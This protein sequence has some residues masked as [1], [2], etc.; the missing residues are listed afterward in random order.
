MFEAFSKVIFQPIMLILTYP[1][2]IYEFTFSIVDVLFFGFW[3]LMLGLIIKC[4][5]GWG[6]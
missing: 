4:I 6:N 5:V 2:H 3:C 1:I